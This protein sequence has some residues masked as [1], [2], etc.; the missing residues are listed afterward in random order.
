MASSATT[1]QCN[2]GSLGALGADVRTVVLTWRVD[3]AGPAVIAANASVS[4]D[5]D[6]NPANN[7][8]DNTTTVVE[9]GNL[10]LAKSGTPSPVPGG[11]VITYTL[12]ASNSGPN[13]GGAMVITDNLP[14]AVSF[15]SAAGTGWTCSHSGGVVRCSRPGPL[16]VD[17]SKTNTILS[18]L[19]D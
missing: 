16:A 14:P 6:I 19:D 8:Q 3:I 2:L 5:N 12:T 15:L 13:A 9:G 18:M 17:D 4:A 7:N 10:A 1:V 11:S